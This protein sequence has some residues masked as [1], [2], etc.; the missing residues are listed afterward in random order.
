MN[1]QEGLYWVTYPSG[2]IRPAYYNG[3]SEIWDILGNNA[4]FK[5]TDFEH[6]NEHRIKK[7][8]ELPD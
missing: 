4:E 3:F 2:L 8:G 5:D 7:P 6:I 1:R